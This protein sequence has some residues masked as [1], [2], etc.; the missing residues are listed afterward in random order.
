M[1]TVAEQFS[2]AA[3]ANFESNLA[4]FT[5]FTTKAFAGV[6]KLIDLNL[7]AAKAS[8]ADSNATTQKLFAAKDPQEFFTLSAALAQPNTEKAIAYG[9][10]FSSIATSTHAELSK[11]SE[12]QIAEAKLKLIEFVSQVSKKVPQGAEGTMAFLKS[13]IDSI[14]A[15]YEQFAKRDGYSF[16]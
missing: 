15:G 16:A 4:L 14:N 3:K 8:L 5:E 6:E 1:S 9:R 2:A 10:H 12:A 7:S 13:T 11:A